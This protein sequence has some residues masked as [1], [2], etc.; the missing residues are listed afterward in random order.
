MNNSFQLL[1]KSAPTTTLE[2]HIEDCLQ[3]EEQLKDC[4]P[5]LPV[6]VSE[7][8][9]L[10]RVAICFHDTG[11][12]HQEFQKLLYKKNNTWNFRRHETNLSNQ[13]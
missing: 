11:K 6:D 10:V 1:A 12:C 4:F 5:N 7:F 3:I 9:K 13:T 2:Q 8:W